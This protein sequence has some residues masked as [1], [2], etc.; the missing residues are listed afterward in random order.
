MSSRLEFATARMPG[1]GTVKND[2]TNVL[3]T[4]FTLEVSGFLS[5]LAGNLFQRQFST[6]LTVFGLLIA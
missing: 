3:K 6:C 1:S 4:C 5:Y 2:V